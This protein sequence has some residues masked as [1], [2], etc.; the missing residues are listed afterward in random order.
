MARLKDSMIAFLTHEEIQ[1]LVRRLAKEIEMDYHGKEIIL[2]CPLKGSCLFAADLSRNIE[3][4]QQIDFV[5]LGATEKKGAIRMLKD[6]G[7][8]IAGKH[9]I[10]VEEIID[11]AR[12]LSFLKHRLLASSPASLKIVTLLDKPARRELPIKPDYVGMTIE[13]RYMVGYGMDSEEI[14]RNYRDIYYFTQ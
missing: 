1:E 10:I 13:D 8:N 6:I 2:I 7:T 9:V 11:T 5:Q 4:S 14:G 12:T 3:L